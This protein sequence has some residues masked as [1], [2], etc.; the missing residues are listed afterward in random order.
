MATWV[1]EYEISSR[2]TARIEADSLAHAK[3]IF[4]AEY[5]EGN[6]PTPYSEF[7]EVDSRIVHAAKEGE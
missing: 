1:I 2:Y 3:D 7:I 4:E 6:L 5:D